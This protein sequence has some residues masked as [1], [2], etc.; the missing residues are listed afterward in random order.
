MDVE[1]V[2]LKECRSL[3]SAASE[4]HLE[5]TGEKLCVYQGLDDAFT[6]IWEALDA[7]PGWTVL[8]LDEIDHITQDQNYD[9][10]DFVYRLLR[11]EGKLSRGIG[12]SV[13][14]ISNELLEVDIRLDS[15]VESAMGDESVFFPPYHHA[16]LETVMRPRLDQAFRAGALPDEVHEQGLQ[17][18]ARRWGDARKTMRLFRRAGETAG[19]RGLETV[20]IDCLDANFETTDKEAVIEKITALP[21]NHLNVL[22]AA[23]GWRQGDDIV[24][25]VT[26]Q[27]IVDYLERDAYSD[28]AALSARTVRDSV[29]DLETMGLVET[30]IES[31]GREGQ[32]KQIKTA[33]DPEWVREA[34]VKY[35]QVRD[36]VQFP[37]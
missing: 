37:D 35:A 1:Y 22:V 17:E 7:Y 16:E 4:I 6:G 29:V 2:N 9:P 27:E 25:P 26:T 13:W 15:R 8:L 34:V 20:T 12:L 18:A 31:R 28:E 5:V 19:E 36:A 33:F 30:W 21:F 3:F 32:V 10:S 24:Q 14:P 11:G 23:T